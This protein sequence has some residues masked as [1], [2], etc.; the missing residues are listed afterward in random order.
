MSHVTQEQA[1]KL[2]ELGYPQDMYNFQVYRGECLFTEIVDHYFRPSAEELME[3]LSSQ[4]EHLA[5]IYISIWEGNW[6]VDLGDV[7]SF[8][9]KSLINALFE[10]T[11]WVLEG[12]K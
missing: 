12:K 11:C 3:W 10:A 8:Y 6:R 7:I 9:D 4:E 5:I 1:K 2:K